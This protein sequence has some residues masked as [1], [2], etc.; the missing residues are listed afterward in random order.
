MIGKRTV[1]DYN[2]I[3]AEYG[4]H[5]RAH[6]GV[7]E[8]LMSL[9]TSQTS[10]IVLEVG[11]GTGNYARLLAANL[12]S[13]VVGIDPSRE[14]LARVSGGTGMGLIN[15]RAEM[16]PLRDESAGLVYSV[17][18]IHHIRDRRAA[19][20]EA[21]RAL[22]PG[23]TL[24]IA[25]DSEEDIVR[26]VP[27]ASHFPETV[28][29]E[30]ARYPTIGAIIDECEHAGF[31]GVET[32]HVVLHYDLIDIQ[33]YRDK[34]FSS[35]HLISTQSFEAGIARLERELTTGP[36]PAMSH[37]TIVVARKPAP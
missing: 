6:P 22:V 15:A 5:R 24:A 26:R 28:A 37:Y 8:A 13:L 21:L 16:L 17:D 3:A 25:T 12:E 31:T 33:P 29:A 9:A 35:L 14:M 4:R 7:L 10:G 2:A 20:R 36:I 18:V 23:G 34:A 27:L 19:A 1:I 30:H 32:R 11:V